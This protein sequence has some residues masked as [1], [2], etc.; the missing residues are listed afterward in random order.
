MTMV[1]SRYKPKPHRR[2]VEQMSNERLK[3]LDEI[4]TKAKAAM[5][6]SKEVRKEAQQLRQRAAMLRWGK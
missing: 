2:T 4:V 1:V 3:R 6:A 5:A